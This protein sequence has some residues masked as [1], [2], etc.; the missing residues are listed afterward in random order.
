MLNIC[1]Q[2][3]FKVFSHEYPIF[4]LFVGLYIYLH[5]CEKHQK[6]PYLFVIDVTI[7]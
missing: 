6:I 1:H 4:N 2:G 3:I 7:D 5:A